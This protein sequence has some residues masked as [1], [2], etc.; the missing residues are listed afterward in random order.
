MYICIYIYVCIV[1]FFLGRDDPPIRVLFV[2]IVAILGNAFIKPWQLHEC[3][4]S[5]SCVLPFHVQV[6]FKKTKTRCLQNKKTNKSSKIPETQTACCFPPFPKQ[7]AN[8]PPPL[9]PPS[10]FA[11]SRGRPGLHLFAASSRAGNP[12]VTA[13]L[14]M[15][16]FFLKPVGFSFPS[17]TPFVG[18]FWWSWESE[19]IPTRISPGNWGQLPYMHINIYIYISVY[20]NS[21][22]GIWGSVPKSAPG[23]ALLPCL[24]FPSV[25]GGRAGDPDH[26]PDE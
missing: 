14:E 8:I 1:C 7:P 25:M 21:T 19:I 18:A 3:C 6:D 4:L 12:A 16:V 5:L 9:S 20:I 23:D 2:G 11:L 24:L 10:W 17:N 13:L 15:E 22:R 26:R